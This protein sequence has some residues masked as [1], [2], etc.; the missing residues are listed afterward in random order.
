MADK[1]PVCPICKKAETVPATR[2]FCSKRCAEVDLY[3]WLGGQYAIPAV[4]PPDEW[5][6]EAALEE[7]VAQDPAQDDELLH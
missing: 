6:V 3:R 2:P 7:E 5:E 4:E 1:K